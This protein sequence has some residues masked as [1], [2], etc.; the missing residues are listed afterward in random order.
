MNVDRTG[1]F[2]CRLLEKGTGKTKEK[3]YPQLI[4][5]VAMTQLY[6]PKG[7]E[8]GE[9]KWFDVSD[10]DMETTAYLCLFSVKKKETEPSRTFHCEDIGKVFSWDGESLA[11]LDKEDHNGLEFQVRIVEN[12][13]EGARSPFQV[14][15]IAEF[16]ADP[17]YTIRKLDAKEVKD[18]DAQF[19]GGATAS[20][21]TAASAKGPKGPKATSKP[22]PAR[23]P[24]DDGPVEP[25][26]PA[27]SK[28]PK[29]M[30]TAEKKA[31]LKKKSDRIKQEA[32]KQRQ[33][34]A[35]TAAAPAVPEDDAPPVPTEAGGGGSC[36]KAEAW[37]KI[38]EIRDPSISDAVVKELWDAAIE[39]VT[40]GGVTHKDITGEQ[41]WQIKDIVIK[42]CGKF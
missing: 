3:G 17:V 29:K 35:A 9:G 5:K 27:K 31:L 34:K 16:D 33:A 1:T 10:W 26:A 32:A 25:K 28:D 30:S 19:F 36:T 12:N 18:L 4:L 14:G 42:D 41:W 2:R 38:F 8:D 6:E 37:A 15:N 20:A 21:K 24:A 7:G 22:H 39:E 23:V 40:G 13:Y 11:A